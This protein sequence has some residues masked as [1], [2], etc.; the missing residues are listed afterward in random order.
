MQTLSFFRSTAFSFILI[1][2]FSSCQTEQFDETTPYAIQIGKYRLIGDAI[3]TI[4][5]VKSMGIS[6]YLL[7]H[8][9]KK[10]G[11]WYLVVADA[12]SSLEETMAN[13]IKYEDS[14]GILSI[15]IINFNSLKD[16]IKAINENDFENFNLATQP[17]TVD[18]KINETAQKLHFS[19]AFQLLEATIINTLDSVE[20]MR[21]SLMKSK[22]PDYPRGIIPQKL[23]YNSSCVAEGV[24]QD[25]LI[26]GNF[27]AQVM[28]LKSTHPYGDNIAEHFAKKIMD[29][30]D[31]D[32]EEM[33][34]V[35]IDAYSPL[36]G[37]LVN[38]EPK[39]GRLI[40][41]MVLSDE[42]QGFLY[43]LQSAKCKEEQ[44]MAFAK[45]FGGTEGITHYTHF[46][47]TFTTLPTSPNPENQLIAFTVEINRESSKGNLAVLREGGIFSKSVFRNTNELG[48]WEYFIQRYNSDS[49]AQKI[50][51]VG[52][53]PSKR[54]PKDSLVVNGQ[55]GWHTTLRRRI[56]NSLKLQDVNNEV[57]FTT[58]NNIIILSNKGRGRIPK[59][60]M[61]D[62]AAQLQLTEELKEESSFW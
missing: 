36:K 62:F 22:V 18:A 27:T 35:T 51:S 28:K 53:S 1:Y 23:I 2:L 50:F 57:Q 38:I 43:F 6:P 32:F 15:D 44:I 19:N 55:Q 26:G 37:Y 14:Y 7:L 30:R 46:Y 33:L 11:E 5:R 17:P 52:Y 54:N 8:K 45:K 49:L 9:D 13:K 47:N 48:A 42:S 31:Y 61:M 34:P 10:E 56:P 60:N 39:K 41:Y 40:R 58:G 4:Q 25:D 24:Y 29:T 59:E 16:E 12:Y 20:V 3:K 21:I